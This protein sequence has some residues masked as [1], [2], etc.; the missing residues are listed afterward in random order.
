MT[1]RFR[2]RL[3]GLLLSGA[4]VLTVFLLVEAAFR[5][6]G[7]VP[8]RY[9]APARMVDARFRVLLDCYPSNP[10]GYFEIDLR[11]PANAEKYR[12]LAP[13]RFDALVRRVAWAL[14][15]SFNRPKVPER[16][17]CPMTAGRL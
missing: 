14:G 1:P 3:K 11:E 8:E 5:L 12:R 2:E 9:R 13:L 10:R 6:G 4:S 16:P 17:F 7:F 15:S